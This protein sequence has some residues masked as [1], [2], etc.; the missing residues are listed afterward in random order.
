M[1]PSA[2]RVAGVIPR[3]ESLGYQVI[4]RGNIMREFHR[5]MFGLTDRAHD[6]PEP[7]IA[8]LNKQHNT[9]LTMLIGVLAALLVLGIA[10]EFLVET[11][12]S[13]ERSVSSW[14]PVTR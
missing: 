1:G 14:R 6:G 3:L 8:D 4:D 7:E 5:R 2:V 10:S 9:F 12:D 13:G 11:L